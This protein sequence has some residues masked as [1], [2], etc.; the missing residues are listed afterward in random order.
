[1]TFE[2]EKE[3]PTQSA[4]FVMTDFLGQFL[5]Y[6]HYILIASLK[7]GSQIADLYPTNPKAN[8][9]VVKKDEESKDQQNEQQYFDRQTFIQI[10]KVIQTLIHVTPY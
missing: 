4:N 10:L 5:R 6:M 3:N 8:A 7:E 2:L 1:M 9:T